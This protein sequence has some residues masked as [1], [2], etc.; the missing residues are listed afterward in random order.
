MEGGG[1]EAPLCVN[2]TEDAEASLLQHKEPQ[3]KEMWSLKSK[4]S[5]KTKKSELTKKTV[6]VETELICDQWAATHVY[7]FTLAEL[8]KLNSRFKIRPWYKNKSGHKD[9]YSIEMWNLLSHATQWPLSVY[10]YGSIGASCSR[11]LSSYYDL[12]HA[13][14]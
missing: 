14:R 7:L 5:S 4:K 12:K 6:S 11:W 9:L 1:V 10:R 8:H 13:S 2:M 3:G